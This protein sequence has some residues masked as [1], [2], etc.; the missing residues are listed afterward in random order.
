MLPMIIIL[1][2]Q[3][4]I[5]MNL[6][7]RPRSIKITTVCCRSAMSH[8]PLRH[9]R[10]PVR[11]GASTPKYHHHPVHFPPI[12]SKYWTCWRVSDLLIIST[13]TLL[14]WQIQQDFV[15]AALFLAL[16]EFCVISSSRAVKLYYLVSAL[17]FIFLMSQFLSINSILLYWDTSAYQ[18]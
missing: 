6:I 2:Q 18:Q 12:H 3:T 10:I 13:A 15:F 9:S 11:S 16:I 8:K 17:L 1:L 14:F 7:K 5:I 4:N